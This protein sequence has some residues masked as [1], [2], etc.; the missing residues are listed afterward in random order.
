MPTPRPSRHLWGTRRGRIYP[1]SRL[2]MD[3]S[4]HKTMKQVAMDFS[5]YKTMKQVEMDF[6]MT[7]QEPVE[8]VNATEV[9]IMMVLM[10]IQITICPMHA[11]VE[12]S[13]QVKVW[14]HIL[15]ARE[16]HHWCPEKMSCSIEI[17]TTQFTNPTAWQTW[18]SNHAN[19]HTWSVSEEVRLW[20]PHM[21]QSSWQRLSHWHPSTVIPSPSRQPWTADNE[22]N[23][24]VQWRWN[25]HWSSWITHSQLST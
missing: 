7:M 19:E 6:S 9:V 12:V 16:M 10:M 13:M 8:Q 17:S 5:K 22:T 23:G 25:A 1:G 15:L 21:H 20:S 11:T 3:F 14:D 4:N 2:E 24:N 18:Q